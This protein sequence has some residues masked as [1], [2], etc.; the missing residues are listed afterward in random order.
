LV[1]WDA[2]KCGVLFCL[3]LISFRLT[4]ISRRTRIGLLKIC[5]R[6]LHALTVKINTLLSTQKLVWEAKRLRISV[7]SLAV[8]A[9]CS[10][11]RELEM[12]WLLNH[13]FCWH[14]LLCYWFL[15]F[16]GIIHNA[17][18]L[19]HWMLL[20]WIRIW[21]QNPIAL[22]CEIRC[23]LLHFKY[24]FCVKFIFIIFSVGGQ[25]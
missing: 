11:L 23:R 12:C 15:L 6:L 5:K 9:L 8:I 17:I 1:E 19:I 10:W 20:V 7:V 4:S 25:V 3:R 22:F 14:I 21:I 24:L 16:N 2:Y 13:R 18:D